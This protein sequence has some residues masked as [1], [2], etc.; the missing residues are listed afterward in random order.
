M[1]RLVGEME[2]Q[3]L[4]KIFA[5]GKC[6]YLHTQCYYTYGASDL[7]QRLLKTRCSGQSAFEGVKDVLQFCERKLQ[8]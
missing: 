3:H 5:Y 1:G 7:D 8:N 2:T 4:P 6:L